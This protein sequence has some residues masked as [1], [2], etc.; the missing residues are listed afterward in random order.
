MQNSELMQLNESITVLELT[1]LWVKVS[2]PH[3]R[4]LKLT[5]LARI[6]ASASSLSL[7]RTLT[8]LVSDLVLKLLMGRGGGLG[9]D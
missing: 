6:R 2:P 8:C 1:S 5:A 9:N 4:A 7:N 3:G